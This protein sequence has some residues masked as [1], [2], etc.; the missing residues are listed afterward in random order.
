MGARAMNAPRAALS[1]LSLALRRFLFVVN[2]LAL[3]AL[4]GDA[5]RVTTLRPESP[6]TAVYRPKLAPPEMLQ[7]FLK[8]LEP[9][10]DAFLAERDAREL[11]RL[12][13]TN[14]HASA[15]TRVPPGVQAE[16]DRCGPFA[17]TGGYEVRRTA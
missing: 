3:T 8:Y 17:F 12:L 15:G 13:Q 2:I 16:V 6:Q 10:S 1:D 14:A 9:G 5:A 7:P 4:Y 11:E